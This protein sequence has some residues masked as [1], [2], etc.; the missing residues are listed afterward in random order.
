MPQA[1]P[2]HQRFGVSAQ[3]FACEMPQA[4]RATDVGFHVAQ[5]R[6]EVVEVGANAR[7][8]TREYRA[9]DQQKSVPS[10]STSRLSRDRARPPC[11]RDGR[12]ARAWCPRMEA[13]HGRALP[14]GHQWPGMDR[15][16]PAIRPRVAMYTPLRGQRQVTSAPQRVD[17]YHPRACSLEIPSQVGSNSIGS[18]T[19]PGLVTSK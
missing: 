15:P 14:H 7:R 5:R 9:S 8:R 11:R 6:K 1:H 19:L 12:A 10:Q 13:R 16:A 18:V 3:C 17:V 2:C 4:V